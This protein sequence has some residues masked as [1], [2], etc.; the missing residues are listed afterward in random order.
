M[1][2]RSNDISKVNAAIEDVVARLRALVLSG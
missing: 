2:A 1:L